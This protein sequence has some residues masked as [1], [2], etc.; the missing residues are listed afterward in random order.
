MNALEMNKTYR[1]RVITLEEAIEKGLDPL[2]DLWIHPLEYQAKLA[3]I[4]VLAKLDG[5]DLDGKWYASDGFDGFFI[6]ENFL[7]F[8]DK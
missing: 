5:E 2:D 4:E 7:E 6:H 3:G 1:C 8:L